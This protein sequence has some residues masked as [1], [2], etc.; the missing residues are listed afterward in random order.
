[1]PID[2]LQAPTSP[3]VTTWLTWLVQPA[4]ILAGTGIFVR[5][6]LWPALKNLMRAELQVELKK[7]DDHHEQIRDVQAQAER[8]DAALERLANVP[9]VLERI[10]T[11][12][13]TLMER[14]R[15]DRGVLTPGGT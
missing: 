9:V 2:S 12:V 10:E 1:M 13:R 6:V 3:L 11:N 7:L 5:L 15:E 8:H 4:V 14:R